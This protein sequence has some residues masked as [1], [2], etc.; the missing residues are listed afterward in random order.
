[1]LCNVERFDEDR[2]F[3]IEIACLRTQF[4]DKA[5]LICNEIPS[6]AQMYIGKCGHC[7]RVSLSIYADA[8]ELDEP[9]MRQLADRIS[10]ILGQ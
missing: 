3:L 2:K 4:D 6:L 8:S 7:D 1:M 10:N 9:E 5:S